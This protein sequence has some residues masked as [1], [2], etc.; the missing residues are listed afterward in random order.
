MHQPNPSTY[1][2]SWF[3]LCDKTF[4]GE[5]QYKCPLTP[6]RQPMA[7]QSKDNIKVKVGE[8]VSFTG[9]MSE[10]YVWG[11]TYRTRSDPRTA[12]SPKP[13]QPWMMPYKSWETEAYCTAGRQLNCLENVLSKWHSW[14][15]PLLRSSASFWFS[16]TT[17]LFSSSSLQLFSSQSVCST[18][19]SSERDS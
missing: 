1:Y 8:P 4:S 18:A 15:T 12:A 13:T 9:V 19:S 6:N 10:G 3:V 17:S 7:D 11:V 5:A 14:S 2:H 16:Q